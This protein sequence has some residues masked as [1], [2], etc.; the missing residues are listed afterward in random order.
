MR[1]IDG[2]EK[3]PVVQIAYKLSKQEW[4]DLVKSMIGKGANVEDK[5]VPVLVDYPAK[6]NGK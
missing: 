6:T 2:R 3:Y 4:G 1:N 5:D